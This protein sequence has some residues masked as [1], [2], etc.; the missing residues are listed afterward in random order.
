[1]SEKRENNGFGLSAKTILAIL[2]LISL[3]PYRYLPK[4]LQDLKN[5]LES[6]NPIKR[7]QDFFTSMT[8]AEALFQLK[9]GDH[10]Y[11]HRK[12]F[13]SHHGIYAGD[14]MV[15]E[16]DGKTAAD[17]EIKLSTL[18]VFAQGDN[19]NRLNY[20][21]DFLP[22]EILERASSRKFEAE[23]NLLSNN[24]MHFAFWCRLASPEAAKTAKEV[25]TLL[26][27]EGKSTATPI[28]TTAIPMG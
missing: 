25:F 6:V 24:C 4:I 14:G 12:T 7:L 27:N 2:A 18:S 1:M 26:L 19:I 13:Y 15:W 17:A 11:C 9:P 16:Y 28:D 23:Y 21:A 5:V 22:E 3:V 8:E 20:D 10:I